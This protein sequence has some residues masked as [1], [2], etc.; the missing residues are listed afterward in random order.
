MIVKHLERVFNDHDVIADNVAGEFEKLTVLAKEL[1]IV[2][3]ELVVPM[4]QAA[5]KWKLDEIERAYAPDIMERELKIQAEID[6]RI[7]KVLKHLVM[8]KEYKKYYVGNGKM[9]EAPSAKQT[10]AAERT[11]PAV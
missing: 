4:L 6:R 8:I 5:E 9:I 1:N 7:D 2:S 11:D 10:D 3:K